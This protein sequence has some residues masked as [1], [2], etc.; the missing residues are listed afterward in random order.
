MPRLGSLSIIGGD[1]M[2]RQ[3]INISKTVV[4]QVSAG[5]LFSP[6][7]I[8]PW[9]FPTSAPPLYS[10]LTRSSHPKDRSSSSHTTKSSPLYPP[11][12]QA[13]DRQPHKPRLVLDQQQ[14]RSKPTITKI[15]Q[16]TRPPQDHH[17]P[18]PGRRHRLRRAER[19]DPRVQ[20]PFYFGGK[21][22]N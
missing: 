8:F 18:L 19:T 1:C 22:H 5:S 2:N 11:P 7:I 3:L 13:R 21:R 4:T 6:A 9:F 16:P 17:P 10:L 15:A 14:Q 20:S 12:P